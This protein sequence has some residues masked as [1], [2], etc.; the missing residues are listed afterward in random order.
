MGVTH[1]ADRRE[2]EEKKKE[3]CR[4]TQA[5]E[6]AKNM[7]HETEII[8]VQRIEATGNVRMVKENGQGEGENRAAK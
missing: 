2:T 8:G 4:K 1:N 5:R 3:R 6:E 7:I